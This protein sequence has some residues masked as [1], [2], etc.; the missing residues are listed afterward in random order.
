MKPFAKILVPVDFS[1]HSEQA[2]RVAA[3]LARRY[4]AALDIIHIYEPLA[5]ALPEGYVLLSN[6]QLKELWSR[7]EKDLDA[8]KKLA[9]EGGAP[10]IET[11]LLQG[12][13]VDEIC[14]VAKKQGFDLIVMGTQ[15]RRGL[16]HL[17][18]GSV[19]ERVLRLAPC[20]VLTLKA[21]KPAHEK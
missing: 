13:A 11:H 12:L 19:A 15:G 10:R 20:P 9:V 4:D 7:L 17:L 5:Y 18:V 2:V 21:P 8:V 6:E 14:S 1:A 16:S 3:E